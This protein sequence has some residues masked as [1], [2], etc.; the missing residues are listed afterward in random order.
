MADFDAARRQLTGAR[1]ADAAARDEASAARTALRRAEAAVVAAE[2]T[3]E[4]QD[5][6][7]DRLAAAVAAAKARQR[8]ASEQR[9]RVR[10]ELGG[11]LAAFAEFSDPRHEIGRLS[12]DFPILLFPVR[13][14]TRF[15]TD[16]QPPQLWVRIYPDTCLIDTFEAALAEVEVESARRYWEGIWGAGGV[17]AGERGA[18][19]GLVA[20]HGSG[21]A[22]WIVDT[23]RPA[24][25]AQRPAK[26]LPR[27]EILVVSVRAALPA[28]EATA[29][30]AFWRAMWLA[31][32]AAAGEQAARAALS[33]AVGAVRA[34]ELEEQTVPVN[35]ADV[36]APPLRKVDVAVSVAFVVLP[37]PPATKD[38]SW[39]QAPRV[40]LLPDRFVLIAEGGDQRIELVGAPVVSP[41]MAGPDPFAAPADQ[42]APDGGDLKVPDE[43]LWMSDFERAIEVGLAFKVDL[44]PIQAS[45]GFERLTV[46][47]VRISADER[48]GAAELERLLTHHANGRAGLKLLAQG[49]PTNNTED[50]GSG[51]TRG[52]DPDVSFDERRAGE[53]FVPEADPRRKSD[54]QWLAELLGLDPLAL[55]RVGGAGGLDQRDARAMQ[56]AL[57]PATLGYYL[58]AMMAPLIGDG[59]VEHT[60]WFF[61]RHVSGRGAAPAIRIGAQPY[62]ILPTTA[63][64]RIGWLRGEG[65]QR[66]GLS[67]DRVG[68]LLRLDAMLRRVESDWATMAA[69]AP[70]VGRGMDA[71]KTLL[72]IL[73]LQPTSAEFHYR[74]AETLNAL[75]NKLS[76]FNLGIAVM[77]ALILA[78]LDARAMALLAALGSDGEQRPA[79]LERY[80]LGEQGALFG[81]LVDDRPLSERDP[82]RPTWTD[83]GRSWLRWMIDAAGHSLDELRTQTGFVDGKPPRALLYLLLRHALILGYGDA[84]RELH[85]SAGVSSEVLQ[86]MR[87]EPAFIHIDPQAA[88]SESRWAPLYAHNPVISPGEDWTV[89]AQIAHVLPVAPETGRLREQLDALELLADAST[90]RLE[91]AMSE[92]IDCCSYRFDAWR[93][94]FVGLQLEALR[95][96]GHDDQEGGGARRG[97]HL[98]AYA[99][100]GGPAPRPA[101]ADPGARPAVRPGQ[102]LRPGGRPAAQAR[103]H[104]RRAH[105]RAV[106]QPRRHRGGAAQRL[107]GQR[108]AGRRRTRW[109]STCRRIACATRWA[110]STGS[111]TG[112]A[113]A[114]CSATASSAA[115]TTATPGSSSTASSSRCARRS[116]S[117]PTS[118]PR[119]PPTRVCRSRPSPR[120]TC[121]TVAGSPRMCARPATR[122]IPSA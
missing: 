110:S 14:E 100:A 22:G 115:C 1:D 105:P 59:D 116:R 13:L 60:R 75:F 25:E 35:F 111:A 102:G 7:H 77:E 16:L 114:R 20:S 32:G 104:Q 121:S 82:I 11:A 46:L 42:F 27:D 48:Q 8:E 45:R 24:N 33:A 69:Q 21:R 76:L 67:R 19:A 38:Q 83:D 68:Y 122:A 106:A 90:A 30:A 63:F 96:G 54:G 70:A 55:A 98:G 56:T 80:F 109:R 47:G 9:A 99:L 103:Q 43:L 10:D 71:H 66:L 117:R 44:T 52:D 50:A 89:A 62:G 97:I 101:R 4:P 58:D 65:A 120:A 92:H 12:D 87:E 119:R 26:V 73:G 108:D 107:P 112:R 41:L 118:S 53:L 31:D 113:S 91:R 28:A 84:G 2:R 95:A 49:T 34:G 40:D 61:T 64:S 72:G 23:Y 94:G 37:D 74:Y 39:S 85:R 57:W 36:P 5:P 78:D 79:I 3:R 6:E 88:V 93:L 29:V 18:W 81:D 15:R 17:E 86:A 51:Y